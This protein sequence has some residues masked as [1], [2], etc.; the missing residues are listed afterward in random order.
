MP[1][2]FRTRPNRLLPERKPL[3]PLCAPLRRDLRR[4]DAPQL[5]GVV[6]EE[7]RVEN[8]A[9]TV[10]VE[11][12]ERFLLAL[13]EARP[14]VVHPRLERPDEPHRQERRRLH[15]DRVIE[16]MTQIVDAA[17]A[18][19]AQH[20]D[21]IRLG[22]GSARL[23]IARASQ[24]PIILRRLALHRHQ[25]RPEVVHLLR[26][27]E[28]AVSADVDAGAVVHGRARNATDLV[29]LLEDDDL[30]FARSLADEFMRR[31]QPRRASPDDD[32]CLHLNIISFRPR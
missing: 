5:L 18:S 8:L 15:R 6:L 4:M 25:F 26:L 22:I 31:R 24:E 1:R 21:I 29:R 17:H 30:P 23:H 10:D 14:D 27:R 16:E 2:T 20:H 13:E 19:T 9:E 11:V 32:C 3:H 7:H 28:E 12:L